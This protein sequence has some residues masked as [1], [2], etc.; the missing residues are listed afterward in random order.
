MGVWLVLT[1]IQTA[2][3]K[4]QGCHNNCEEGEIYLNSVIRDSMHSNDFTG[5]GY[6]IY[7]PNL[8]FPSIPRLN[9]NNYHIFLGMLNN[10]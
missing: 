8:G 6:T 4:S 5:I 2:G 3:A 10:S 1:L 9:N 7:H